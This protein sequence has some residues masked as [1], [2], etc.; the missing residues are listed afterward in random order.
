MIGTLGTILRAKR[1]GLIASAAQ[2]I[3]A[4]RAAGL[5]LDDEVVRTSLQRAAGETWPE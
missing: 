5:R 1:A 2:A 4:L 3:V